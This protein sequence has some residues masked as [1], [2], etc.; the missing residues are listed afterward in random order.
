[1]ASSLSNLVNNLAEGIHIIQCKY[2]Y[3]HKNCKT[4]RNIYKDCE[5]CLEYANVKDNLIRHKC[6]YCNENYQKRFLKI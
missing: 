2:G 1:M 6:L 4:C 3:D 5:C